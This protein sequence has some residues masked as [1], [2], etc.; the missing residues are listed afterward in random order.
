MNRFACL[1]LVALFSFFFF[2]CEKEVT[3]EVYSQ[4]YVSLFD[5]DLKTV[6]KL[7]SHYPDL[8][9]WEI[10]NGEYQGD[11]LM[12]AIVQDKKDIAEYLLKKG[13]IAWYFDD[14]G[15]TTLEKAVANNRIWAIDMLLDSGAEL[16]SKSDDGSNVFHTLAQFYQSDEIADVLISKEDDLAV[17]DKETNEGV[18]PLAIALVNSNYELANKFLSKGA[19]MEKALD[20]AFFV[21]YQ[22]TIRND[23][24]MLDYF[25]D[26][27]YVK[28]YER[29]RSNNYFHYAVTWNNTHLVKRLLDD[30][31]WDYSE[32]HEGET[33]LE[34]AE[35]LDRAEIIQMVQEAGLI[36]E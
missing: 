22:C 33:P 36:E 27:G 30:D 7:I 15:N 21:P 13:A 23:N 32:N 17:I 11:P 19:D 12:T 10:Q 34:I 8:I 5:G 14:Y 31:L 1:L 6:K 20:S 26:N 28:P 24:E 3:H 29:F 18:T 4:F 35:R 16:T 25:Y 9:T 2:S